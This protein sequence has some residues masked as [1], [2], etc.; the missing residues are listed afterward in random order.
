MFVVSTRTFYGNIAVVA[1]TSLIYFE[2]YTNPKKR[3][4]PLYDFCR[5]WGGFTFCRILVAII[6]MRMSQ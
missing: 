3:Q 4:Y 1:I 6:N 2:S 5:L